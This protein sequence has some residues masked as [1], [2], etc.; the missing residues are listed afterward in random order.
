MCSTVLDENRFEDV[1]RVLTRVDCF[2]ELLVNVFP[3]DERDRI[4][5]SA[6]ETRDGSARKAV[7]LVLE[8]AQLDQLPFR[9]LEALEPAD[10][11]GELLGR[12][13][14]YVRLL[15]GLAA[16]L[17]HAVP[18]DLLRRVV[19]VVADGVEDAGEPEHVVAVER[20]HEGAVD[21]IDQVVCDPVACVLELLDVAHVVVGAVRELVEQLDQALRDRD[22]I[23]GGA[24]VKVEELAL[25]RDE[26]DPGHR[27]RFVTHAFAVRRR[28]YLG[29][30]WGSISLVSR[31]IR[32]RSH[33][34]SPARRSWSARRCSTTT[35]SRGC[36][37]R[38]RL[39]WSGPKTGASPKRSRRTSTCPSRTSISSS[40]S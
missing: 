4:G 8:L 17:L 3:A 39:S 33:L 15:P 20:R 29:C 1:G 18:D 28:R 6:E 16:H 38:A 5:A 31:H 12:T 40:R 22:G 23:R 37:S 9:I 34:A 32:P 30:R 35:E 14:D 26:A 21:Q 36:T 27:H 10:R 11:L 2:L 24:V 19:H 25:L 7:A 13:V